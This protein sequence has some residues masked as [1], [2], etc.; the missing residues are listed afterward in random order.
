MALFSV[1]ALDGRGVNE[2]NQIL[3]EL[4]SDQS[5]FHVR[6]L[7]SPLTLFLRTEK[8]LLWFSHHPWFGEFDFNWL[9]NVF[10]WGYRLLKKYWA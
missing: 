4:D 2:T 8:H 5:A 6:A 9:L 1:M 10:G 3:F 7:D